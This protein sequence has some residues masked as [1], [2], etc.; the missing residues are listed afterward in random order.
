MASMAPPSSGSM[1]PAD[2]QYVRFKD[3]L[4]RTVVDVIDLSL[5]DKWSEERLQSEIR[6]LA[7]KVAREMDRR[8]PAEWVNQAT[9]DVLDEVFGLGPIEPL[10]RDKSITEILVNGPENVFVERNGV[11]E[12]VPIRFADN[13]HLVRVIQRVASRV[14]R[15]IDE[16]SPMVDARLPDGSRVN[17]V[18]APLTIDGAVLSIRRFSA[19]FSMED[20]IARQ[21]LTREMGEFL[22]ACVAARI[23]TII[24]GG[25]GAG[26]TTLLNVLSG[27]IGRNERIVTIEDTLELQLQQKHVVRMET[28]NAN[29]EGYGAVTQRDLVRNALRMRPDRIII[30][31]CRGA[32]A[33]D[34]LQ[35][36]NTGHEGSLTTVHANS[37]RDALARL[38]LM[39]GL[40]GMKV[41]TP[42]LREYISSAIH[43]I[44][45]VARLE[46]GA[47]KVTRI[48]ELVGRG[49]RGGYVVRDV[50]AFEQTGVEAGQAVGRFRATGYA[51]RFLSRLQAAGRPLPPSLLAPRDLLAIGPAVAEAAA[52]Q[53]LHPLADDLP[54]L[55]D[56][57]DIPDAD[58]IIPPEEGGPG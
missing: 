58:I 25:T 56:T 9:E 2:P 23:N 14:G 28:R 29:M 36:M 38:E 26:K 27:Y 20:L 5:L 57:L 45:H 8:M 7:R 42:I 51:P 44:V 3:A 49:K 43:L 10:F 19:I 11:L 35:A 6:D 4:H 30:G 15:R 55:A 50:F 1:T 16:S 46:G 39:V 17:A 13:A 12:R 48:A 40:S 34:M 33:V 32:E 31:E 52:A 22:E 54:P 18:L 41:P 37:A 24:S 47:R 53:S 21:S